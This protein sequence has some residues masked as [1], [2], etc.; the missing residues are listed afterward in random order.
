M[1]SLKEQ[2]DNLKGQTPGIMRMELNGIMRKA[3]NGARE[4]NAEAL[5]ANGIE[6]AEFVRTFASAWVQEVLE[7]KDHHQGHPAANAIIRDCLEIL[8]QSQEYSY[9]HYIDDE[10]RK[11]V[12]EKLSKN[13]EPPQRQFTFRG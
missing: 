11:T 3:N 2:F 5:K 8:D 9:G 12:Q 4:F 6:P 13:Q 7:R 1:T 10:V